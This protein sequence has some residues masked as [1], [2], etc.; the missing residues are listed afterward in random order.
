MITDVAQRWRDRRGSYRWT[1]EPFDPDRYEVAP[2]A[3]DRVARTFVEAH[4]YSGTYPAARFRFGLYLGADLVGVSVFS[5]PT[6]DLALRPL[7]GDP[8][9]SV[10]LGRFVLLDDVR[11]NAESWFLARCFDV[12]R[13]DGIVGVVSFSDPEPREGAD[14]RIVFAGHIGTI[15]QATNAVYVGRGTARTLRLLPDGHTLS[16]RALQKIRKGEPGWRYAAEQLVAHGAAPLAGDP[17]L[18]LARWLLALTRTIRHP[19]NHKYV[20]PLERGA[21]K[22]LPAPR[23]YP[24]F[25]LER[26]QRAA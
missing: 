21:R 8:R 13:R 7:P 3:S 4:H 25:D 9:A 5:V 26:A 10:E 22:H 12:L 18:W 20:F 24:K 15:Y 6:N 2:I 16:A 11:A 14:G 23:P 19:G 17:R 1:G